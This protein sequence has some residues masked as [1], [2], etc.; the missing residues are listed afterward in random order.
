VIFGFFQSAKQI[1]AQKR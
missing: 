1:Q